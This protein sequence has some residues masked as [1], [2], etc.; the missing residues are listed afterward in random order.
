MVERMRSHAPD[1]AGRI[2]TFA[3]SDW[4]WAHL[5]TVVAEA[6]AP[7]DAAAVTAY[8]DVLPEREI[9]RRL[10]GYYVRWFRHGIDAGIVDAAIRGDAVAARALL[11]AWTDEDRPWR[12]SVAARLDAGPRRTKAELVDLVG[13]WSEGAFS[14][15]VAPLRRSFVSAANVRRR[16]LRG[17]RPEDVVAA[18]TGWAYIAEP[19]ITRALV[20]PSLVLAGTIHEF[21]HEQTKV[22]CVPLAPLPRPAS[23]ALV[24]PLRALADPS[25]M[26]IL[27]AL[28]DSSLGAQEIADRTGLSLPTALHHLAVLR[29]AGAVSGGGR[30]QAYRLR[31]RA[32][33]TLGDAIGALGEPSH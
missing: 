27:L 19:G 21:E 22:I 28:R 23:A 8:L 20:I 13:A 4:M 15:V 10:L 30:R 7:R 33:R 26:A 31:A 12:A 17:A 25:R 5:V 32:L 14:T 3:P 9:M 2:S 6:P 1:L 29:A 11:R 24:G 16:A 18:F